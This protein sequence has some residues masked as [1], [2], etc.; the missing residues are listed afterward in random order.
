MQDAL[1][2]ILE[3]RATNTILHECVPWKPVILLY[4]ERI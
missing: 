2:W 1:D 4:S 3:V